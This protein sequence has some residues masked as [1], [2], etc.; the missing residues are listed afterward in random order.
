MKSV[1]IVLLGIW[2]LSSAMVVLAGEAEEDHQALMC[3]DLLVELS[4]PIPPP[5]SESAPRDAG[6]LLEPLYSMEKNKLTL[7]AIFGFS[8]T[9]MTRVL[10][11]MR[12]KA[13]RRQLSTHSCEL[14]SHSSIQARYAARKARKQR[15]SVRHSIRC[16]RTSIEQFH[17]NNMC[18]R[19]P[20]YSRSYRRFAHSPSY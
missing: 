19:R 15:S 10:F 20:R 18:E 8:L 17:M 6:A 2:M 1:V 11:Q 7:L 5:L 9:L 4:M 14:H 3:D 12:V 16:A 13:R